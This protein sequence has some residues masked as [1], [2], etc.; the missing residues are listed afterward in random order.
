MTKYGGCITFYGPSESPAQQVIKQMRFQTHECPLCNKV[1]RLKSNSGVSTYFCPDECE[2]DGN[3]KSHYEVELDTKQS[4]QHLYAFPYAVDNFAN[5]GKSRVYLWD[6]NRW[7]FFMEVAF[8]TAQPQ[9][10]LLKHL[11]SVAPPSYDIAM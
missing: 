3:Y 10:S 5:S 6:G 1:L 7:Q 4:I 11:Y 2:T 8:I 9:E